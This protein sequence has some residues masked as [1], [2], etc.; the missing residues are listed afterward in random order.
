MENIRG[1]LIRLDEDEKQTLG[2]IHF[3][4]GLE[5]VLSVKCLE[6]P[7]RDNANSISRI[8]AKTYKCELRYSEKY[9]W[10]YHVTDVEGR[11]WILIH[12]GNYYRDTRGCILV[13]NGFTDIDGDGYRDVTSSKKT[14]KRILDLVGDCFDLTIIDN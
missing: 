12:F 11:T 14:L 6:L 1:I 5:R 2:E 4:N 7:D 3:Y 10:H 8:I 13:G 9:N